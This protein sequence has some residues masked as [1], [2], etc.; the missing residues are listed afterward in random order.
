MIMEAEGFDLARRQVAMCGDQGQ[1][2][3][4]AITEGCLKTGKLTTAHEAARPGD[5][6]RSRG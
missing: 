6:G 2:F 4:V 1:D 5:R 3:S